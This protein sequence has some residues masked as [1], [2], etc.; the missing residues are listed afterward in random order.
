[1]TV[2]DIIGFHRQQD[3]VI[4][5][6]FFFIRNRVNRAS[7][8][9]QV[10]LDRWV[11]PVYRVTM[12]GQDLRESWDRREKSVRRVSRVRMDRLD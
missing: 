5:E 7:R 6:S 8:V 1:M 4:D 9:H 12:V 11:R 2:F 3:I 10:H